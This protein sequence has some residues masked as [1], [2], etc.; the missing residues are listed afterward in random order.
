MHRSVGRIKPNLIIKRRKGQ[1][2][3]VG[4]SPGFSVVEIWIADDILP[5]SVKNYWGKEGGADT[6]INPTNP[7]LVG[8]S[9]AYFP[10]GGPVP[11]QE[12]G[13]HSVWGGMEA[14]D[15]MRYPTQCVDGRVHME[16]GP[17]LK[18]TLQLNYPSGCAVGKA[19]VSKTFGNLS[20]KYKY[21]HIIHTVPPLAND[22]SLNLDSND[23]LLASCYL[24]SFEIFLNSSDMKIVATPLVGSGT[25]G[26]DAR[27]AIAGLITAICRYFRL[28]LSSF[29]ENKNLSSGTPNNEMVRRYVNVLESRTSSPKVLRV[30]CNSRSSLD[31]MIMALDS[32]CG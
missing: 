26:F 3:Y 9:L 18:K 10:I 4:P 11:R 14:G 13:W 31:K 8:A 6:I 23:H 30:V 2:V 27:V 22:P 15:R 32:Y 5:L 17:M 24:S 19:V 20:T 29:T 21:Q 1:Y 28:G 12:S 7:D 25:A 16:S